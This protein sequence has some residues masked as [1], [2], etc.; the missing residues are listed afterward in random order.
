MTDFERA[1]LAQAVAQRIGWTLDPQRPASEMQ[2]R[3]PGYDDSVPSYENEGRIEIAGKGWDPTRPGADFCEVLEWLFE[4]QTIELYRYEGQVA[5]L[6][7]VDHH[8]IGEDIYIAVCR[9]VVEVG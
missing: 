6:L 4:R 5:F 8:V 7:R 9:A 3:A 1:E 2:I